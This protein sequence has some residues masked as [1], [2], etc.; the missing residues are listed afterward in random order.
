M[1]R[2]SATVAAAA[3]LLVTAC[4]SESA[5]EPTGF[6]RDP[7]PDVGELSLPDVGNGGEEVAFRADPD[8]VLVVYFGYTNCPDFCPT[9]LN[10]LKLAVRRLDESDQERIDVALVTVDPDRDLDILP[11]YLGSFF[12]DGYALGTSDP[13]RLAQV[14]APFGVGY[15]VRETADGIEVD[16]TTFL[17][18][19]DDEGRLTLTWQYGVSIDDLKTDLEILLDEASA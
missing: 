13:T 1:R 18:A 11:Q 5:A 16:H 10:D 14:A 17:Y 6:R 2:R 19:V 3:V 8:E 4:G 7:A 15:D 12:D 9:T